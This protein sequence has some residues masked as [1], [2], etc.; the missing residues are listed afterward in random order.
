MAMTEAN[1]TRGID[2]CIA[3]I[4]AWKVFQNLRTSRRIRKPRH[5]RRAEWP[6]FVQLGRR[7]SRWK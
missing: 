2:S 1:R 4:L 5:D 3:D 7:G 6:R